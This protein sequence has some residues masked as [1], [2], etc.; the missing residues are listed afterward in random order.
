MTGNNSIVKYILQSGCYLDFK[1]CYST[2]MHVAA[3]CGHYHTVKLLLDY[4]IPA[5]IKNKYGNL[6]I[7][8]TDDPYI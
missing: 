7:E 4:G 2:S 5:G 3:W 6:P 1:N 8:E